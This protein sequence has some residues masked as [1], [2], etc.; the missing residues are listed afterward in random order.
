MKFRSFKLK[1]FELGKN[2]FELMKNDEFN[3]AITVHPVLQKEDFYIL[4]A[5]FLKVMY[6]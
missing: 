4:N 3:D 6:T 2:L 1:H 5:Y